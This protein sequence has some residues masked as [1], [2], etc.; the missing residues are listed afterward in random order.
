MVLVC[1]LLLIQVNG[2]YKSLNSTCYFVTGNYFA[3][4]LSTTSN[5]SEWSYR[6]H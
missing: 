2:F 1:L 3:S 5:P 4:C 6:I